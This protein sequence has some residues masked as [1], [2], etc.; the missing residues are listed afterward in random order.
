MRLGGAG[1]DPRRVHRRVELRPPQARR[2]DLVDRGDRLGRRR[3]DHRAVALQRPLLVDDDRNL[4]VGREQ[5][6]RGAALVQVERVVDLGAGAAVVG[7]PRRHV[8]QQV[9]VVAADMLVRIPQPRQDRLA[10]PVDHRRAG[11]GGDRP[12][13]ADR[14]DLAVGDQHRAVGRGSAPATESNRVTWSTSVGVRLAGLRKRWAT[15]RT[16]SAVAAS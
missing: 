9:P 5:V 11:G 8:L 12:R 4:A 1:G 10:A 14:G 16:M 2:L 3:D 6:T 7:H 13:R 15:S